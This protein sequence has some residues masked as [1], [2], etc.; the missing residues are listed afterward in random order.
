MVKD[1]DIDKLI[2]HKQPNQNIILP[3]TDAINTLS[4]SDS[5]SNSDDSELDILN[6]IQK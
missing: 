3:E 1:I 6:M 5:G 2:T 4:F